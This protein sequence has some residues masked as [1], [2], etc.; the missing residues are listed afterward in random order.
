MNIKNNALL[1]CSLAFYSWGGIAYLLLL[2]VSVAVNYICALYMA[3]PSRKR[4]AL[5]IGIFWNLGL[6]FLFKYL[7]FVISLISQTCSFLTDGAVS[8]PPIPALPFPIG[9]SFF[10]FQILS[11]LIDVYR[12]KAE[13][14]RS[15]RDLCLYIMLFPQLIAGPIVRYVDV[16]RELAFRTS[17]P[18]QVQN[19]I[20]RFIIGFLKKIFLA[21]AMGEMA[22]LIF[23]MDSGV[24]ML[25]AWMGLI[26]YSLQIYL[27]FS[28]YSDMAIGLGE[29]FGFRFLENFDHPY[30]SRSITEFWRRWH[31]SLNGWFTD[32]VYIPLGGS[33]RGIFI[34]YRNL[35]LIFVLSG[36]WHGAGLTF[37]CWGL[38]HG[39]LMILE[40]WK[41][42]ALLER[43]P[44]LLRRLYLW[45][46]V[47]MGWVFF[48]AET[49]SA[50]MEYFKN[51][52]S[53]QIFS[54]HE[55]WPLELA[56]TGEFLC[57]FLVSLLICSPRL[58]HFYT[59]RRNRASGILMDTGLLVLFFLAC[60][61]MMANGF[62]P[63][64]YFRF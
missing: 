36:I 18:E 58:F 40:K 52:F 37:L 56:S 48:R 42:K 50:A 1:F 12:G 51:L 13:I 20:C 63:F 33:R 49:L 64:I 24:G 15:I 3:S 4:P 16:E 19:G 31:M 5:L 55:R 44:S 32:Y 11:Y 26:T 6:L 61:E 59:E 35:L 60:C 25:Y 54:G 57:C 34:A 23:N 62:N 28:S 41:L 7:N 14:Q 53:F 47:L 27:D 39:I 9:I 46:V 43:L 29:I 30:C 22:D 38:F 10:T 17:R 2:L 21:N 8:I 45:F